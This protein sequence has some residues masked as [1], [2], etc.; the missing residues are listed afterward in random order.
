MIIKLNGADFSKNNIGKIEFKKELSAETLALLGNYTK[1]LSDTQKYA[2]Q[3]FIV[4][5]K[6]NN[7]WANIGNLYLPILAGTLSES[8]YNVKTNK[9]DV[10]LNSLAYS[11]DEKGIK[12]IGTSTSNVAKI[13]YNGSQLNFHGL[14]YNTTPYDTLTTSEILYAN[15]VSTQNIQCVITTSFG[16]D[17]KTNNNIAVIVNTGTLRKECGFKGVIQGTAGNIGVGFVEDTLSL[18]PISTDNTYTDFPI[19]IL[20]NPAIV[21]RASASTYGIISFG[22]ALTLQQLTIYKSLADKF[23]SNMGIVM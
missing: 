18:N 11:L 19:G 7:I 13:N 6:Q 3:D 14:L 5:L 20:S 1:V 23:M 17:I 4:G 12:S 15:A 10:M 2:F 22:N 9:N 8:M 21:A 16:M